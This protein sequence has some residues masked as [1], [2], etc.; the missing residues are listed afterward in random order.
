MKIRRHGP[1]IHCR[2]KN[3]CTKNRESTF[4]C[5]LKEF[6]SFVSSW[7]LLSNNE[8]LDAFLEKLPD[9]DKSV[10]VRSEGASDDVFKIQ[11]KSN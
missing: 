3:D 4:G 9:A 8:T 6:D 11:S 2:I 5:L 1:Y 10:T 7:S